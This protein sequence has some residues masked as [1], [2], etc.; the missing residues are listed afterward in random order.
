MAN[1]RYLLRRDDG[2]GAGVVFKTRKEVNAF[3]K[4]NPGY[5]EESAEETAANQRAADAKAVEMAE[6]KAIS[7]AENKSR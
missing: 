3:L 5:V 2:S 6:N 7:R 4:V 1:D